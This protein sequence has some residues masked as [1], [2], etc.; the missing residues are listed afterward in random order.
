MNR[1]TI[2]RS[3]ALGL[4]AGGGLLVVAASMGPATWRQGEAHAKPAVA[5][6]VTVVLLGPVLSA[7]SLATRKLAARRIA[8]VAGAGS[9]IAA[10]LAVG[11]A[12]GEA[13]RDGLA[14]GGPLAAVGATLAAGGWL[15]AALTADL[16]GRLHPG[17][18]VGATILVVLVGWLGPVGAARLARSGTDARTVAAVP[19]AEAAPP[20]GLATAWQ[21]TPSGPVA[22]VAGNVVLLR[23]RA[24]VRTLDVRTGRAAWHHLRSGR[25]LVGLGPAAGGGLVVGLWQGD[26]ETLAIAFDAYTGKRRWQRTVDAPAADHQV[27]GSA[28]LVVLVPRGKPAPVLAL[29]V[30]TGERRWAW[31]PANAECAV[32]AAA[33]SDEPDRDDTLAV[34]F[35][36]PDGRRVSG[37]STVDGAVRW[38]WA[39]S[40]PSDAVD[41]LPPRGTAP[42]GSLP[43]GYAPL[44]VPTAGGVLVNDGPTGLVLS[45]SGGRAGAAHPAGGR[46]AA[47]AG[48]TG[49]YLGGDNATAVDLALGRERWKVPLPAATTPVAVAAIEG[50]GFALV[51][52]DRGGP[53]RLVRY[54]LNTGTNLAERQVDDASTGLWLAPG[55]LLVTTT[56]NAVTALR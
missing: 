47:S 35:S 37:L 52:P 5:V 23:E 17:L 42:G 10:A 22:G 32:V 38:T 19:A 39:P 2:I 55:T 28:G 33:T 7:L 49:L 31:R 51:V 8:A 29:D 46:L 43:G 45:M 54:D 18:L 24:G 9:A 56:T 15:V 1:I 25:S 14:P 34:A 40:S 27:T 44:L 50:A 12:A 48:A 21:A 30:R 11:A 53:A 13:T 20:P 16:P 4:V 26:G 41:G 3:G 36:C 6:L